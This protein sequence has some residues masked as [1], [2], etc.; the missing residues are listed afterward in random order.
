MP[1]QTLPPLNHDDY[2]LALRYLKI[3]ANASPE[4]DKLKELTEQMQSHCT[5]ACHHLITPINFSEF[6]QIPNSSWEGSPIV[7]KSHDLNKMLTDCHS[8][9]FIGVTLGP[10]I[11]RHIRTLQSTSPA[12]ALYIDALA[13]VQV[14]SLLNSYIK[15]IRANQLPNTSFSAPYSCGY[16][17]L[18]IDYQPIILSLLDA[19]KK[20]GI[21]LSPTKMM[22]PSKSITSIIGISNVPQRPHFSCIDCPIEICN[23]RSPQ[24]LKRF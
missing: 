18:S 13:S 7:F 17:D 16:G 22:S 8:L 11:D 9:L 5:P 23:P 10:Q 19:N 21:S 6:Y 24:C 14:E 15:E 1:K 3:P 12:G 4:L 20:L 2:L